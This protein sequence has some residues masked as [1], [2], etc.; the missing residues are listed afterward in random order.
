MMFLL[1]MVILTT[2]ILCGLSCLVNCDFCHGRIF[3]NIL[4]NLIAPCTFF[5]FS[6]VVDKASWNKNMLNL[7]FFIS[8]QATLYM[9]PLSDH[10]SFNVE[11]SLTTRQQSLQ[12]NTIFNYSRANIDAINQNLASF[13]KPVFRRIIFKVVK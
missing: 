3:E 5:S 11:F 2:R 9:K 7:F 12:A 8:E 6:Q 1:L 13:L 10:V 4:V